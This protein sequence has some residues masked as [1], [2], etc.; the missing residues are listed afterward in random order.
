MR[1]AFG[2]GCLTIVL[3]HLWKRV[4]I[5]VE[6]TGGLLPPDGEVLLEGAA[7]V[8]AVGGRLRHDLVERL[9]RSLPVLTLHSKEGCESD[10]SREAKDPVLDL[11][12]QD[13]SHQGVGQGPTSGHVDGRLRAELL[14]LVAV[15]LLHLDDLPFRKV[16]ILLNHIKE[17]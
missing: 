15:E 17:S 2:H 10:G 11:G 8:G 1:C 4:A 16:V 9:A 13:R 7:D 6:L 12:A 3:V 5:V 14:E